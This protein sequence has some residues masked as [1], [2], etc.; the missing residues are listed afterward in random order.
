MFHN[1]M[2]KNLEKIHAR[3]LFNIPMA[4]KIVFIVYDHYTTIWALFNILNLIVE[5]FYIN[6]QKVHA[7]VHLY[8]RAYM[9]A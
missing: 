7:K 9:G 6:F 3:A 4:R 5:S 2:P 1:F 8:M